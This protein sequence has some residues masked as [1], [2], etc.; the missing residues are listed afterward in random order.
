MSTD[1]PK[2]LLLREILRLKEEI[3]P[4][5]KRLKKVKQLF[6]DMLVTGGP[7]T[8]EDIGI[9]AY[10]E[11]RYR[12]DYD[13]D[14]LRQEFP[15]LAEDLIKEMVDKPYLE[16]LLLGGVVTDSELEA[17]GVKTKTMISRN[18]TL[19][20]LIKHSMFSEQQKRL[21]ELS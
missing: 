13:P 19:K 10:L 2:A 11:P 17:K 21:E 12:N 15:I 8:D 4:L 9:V 7:F 20:K 5:E 18:L 3:E 1:E 6:K 14:L 16:Q